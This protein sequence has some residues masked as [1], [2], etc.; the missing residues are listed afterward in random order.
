[1]KPVL[2]ALAVAVALGLAS[3]AR[4][5]DSN[6]TIEQTGDSNVAS[7]E[8]V[9]SSGASAA[10]FQTGNANTPAFDSLGLPMIRQNNAANSFVTVRQNG[11]LNTAYVEQLSVTGAEARIE[12]LGLQDRG[13]ISQT[14][15]ESGFAG[16]YQGGAG[17]LDASCESVFELGDSVNN[18]AA[19]VQDAGSRNTALTLQ[20]GSGHQAFIQQ[21]DGDDNFGRLIQTGTGHVADLRQG[22]LYCS[23][24]GCVELGAS[25]LSTTLAFQVGAYNDL[26]IVQAGSGNFASAFQNGQGGIGEGNSAVIDQRGNG[27]T[28]NLFQA[29][30]LN[31]ASITQR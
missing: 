16:V 21:A 17:C 26:E 29:G 30:T 12:Q 11:D 27:L 15:G 18:N 9:G 24:S 2:K 3:H 19:I 31:H 25:S 6:A 8:Q 22:G 4:A 14:S 28:A 1:M 23:A 5:D 13:F 20:G 10:I 7:I